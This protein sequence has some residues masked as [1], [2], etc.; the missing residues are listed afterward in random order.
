MWI[1]NAQPEVPAADPCDH[2]TASRPVLI[3]TSG[4]NHYTARWVVYVD[5]DVIDGIPPCWELVGR[6]GLQ[7]DRE[8]VVQWFDCTAVASLI[9][10]AKC[11]CDYTLTY[12]AMKYSPFACK[13]VGDRLRAALARIGGDA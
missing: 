10:E 2:R 1:T 8:E 4:G 3:Q 7:L 6:E 5:Q 9:E 13:E 12:S 11:V